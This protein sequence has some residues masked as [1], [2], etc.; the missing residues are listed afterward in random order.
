LVKD[1]FSFAYRLGYQGTFAGTA[2]FYLQPYMISSFS[3]TTTIDGL[4]GS[5]T[6]RG[7]LRDRVVG[8]GVGYGN[9]EFRWKFYRFHLIKQ[10]FYLA[11]NAFA[12]AGM[13]LDKV[14]I[15]TASVPDS[16]N[17]AQYFSPG[18]EYPHLAL[19]GGLRIAMN[20]NFIISADM[21]F[22]PDKRDGG[23]GI[24]VGLGYLF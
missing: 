2:P 23:S 19:G 9:L 8:D 10:N 1:V 13:V 24:Y 7:I 18:S 14:K 17:K 6:L 4:G 22:A 21:G 11:L 16:I 12:D 20:Q 3:Q 5:R 15:N